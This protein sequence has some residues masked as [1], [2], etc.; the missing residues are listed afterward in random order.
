[1]QGRI[2]GVTLPGSDLSAGILPLVSLLMSHQPTSIQVLLRHEVNMWWNINFVPLE[3]LKTKV[4]G[5]KNWNSSKTL[6]SKVILQLSLSLESRPSPY[7]EQWSIYWYIIAGK[8]NHATTCLQSIVL[9]QNCYFGAHWSALCAANKDMRV[10]IRTKFHHS[11]LMRY[12]S[13][14]ESKL[15]RANIGLLKKILFKHFVIQD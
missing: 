15:P 2:W 14:L 10:V 8:Y 12:L 6:P 3:N 13:Q 7:R 1:M 9:C 5:F 11:W 4:A